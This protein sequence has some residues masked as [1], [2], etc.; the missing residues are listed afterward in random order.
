VR[1][2]QAD[3]PIVGVEENTDFPGH[4]APVFG[5]PY[6][7][8]LPIYERLDAQIKW[9]FRTRFPSSL[10]LDVI[11]VLNRHNV[12]SQRLDYTLS[13]VGES[14]ILKKYDGFGFL[15]MLSYHVTF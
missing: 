9:T 4:V 1:S 14:P 13:K 6:S 11:N 5:T 10:T 8:R 3:T 12:D 7:T 2:G 15:P